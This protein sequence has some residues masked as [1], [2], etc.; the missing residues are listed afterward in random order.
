[1]KAT[2]K[3]TD[4]YIEVVRVEPVKEKVIN[5]EL[6]EAEAAALVLFFGSVSDGKFEAQVTKEL[7]C[8]FPSQATARRI[9]DRDG[10]PYITYGL[11]REL[12]NALDK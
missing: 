7:N 10:I 6:T 8:G 2:S 5:L 1:M 3:T 4:K 12:R 9:I 11:Y